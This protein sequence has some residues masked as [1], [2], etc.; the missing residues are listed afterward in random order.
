MCFMAGLKEKC[1]ELMKEVLF[2]PIPTTTT[3]TIVIYFLAF[4]RV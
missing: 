2:V 4:S 3:T 1:K